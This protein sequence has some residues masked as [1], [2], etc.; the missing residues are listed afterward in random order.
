[1]RKLGRSPKCPPDPA[2]STAK[3]RFC[4]ETV[5]GWHIGHGPESVSDV[6]LGLA[7]TY[8]LWR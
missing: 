1:V 7:L 6:G 4:G 2:R 5:Q 3:W 8:D